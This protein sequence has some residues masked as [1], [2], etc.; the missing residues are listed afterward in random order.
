MIVPVY[1]SLLGVSLNA[2]TIWGEPRVIYSFLGG[3][4]IRISREGRPLAEGKRLQR[5]LISMEVLG[6][7]LAAPPDHVVGGCG[8]VPQN[9]HGNREGLALFL[10]V[11]S[12]W[13]FQDLSMLY[14]TSSMPSHRVWLT[15][16]WT[17][18]HHT[19]VISKSVSQSVCLSVSLGP[20][21]RMN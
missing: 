4:G 7:W 1:M 21:D 20:N 17:S 8:H 3:E 11:S 5:C 12:L 16:I 10:T 2:N 6:T 19:L 14:L 9:G 13:D 15:L 18:S